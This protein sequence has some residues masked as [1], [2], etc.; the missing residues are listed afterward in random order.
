MLRKTV[1]TLTFVFAAVYPLKA[2]ST[3]GTIIGVVQDETQASIPEVQI[4]ARNLDDNSTRSTKSGSDGSYLFLNV[5]PGRYQI[6][7]AKQEFAVFKIA[8]MQVAHLKRRRAAIG[9][10]AP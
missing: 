4:E 10:Q 9:M 2:Q 1:L 3:F 8:S 6:V 5:R 7:A